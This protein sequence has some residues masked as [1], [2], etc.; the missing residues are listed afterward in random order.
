MRPES[1]SGQLA[2]PD[3]VVELRAVI[4][5]NLNKFVD[6]AGVSQSELARAVGVTP[7]SVSKWLTGESGID[8][9]HIKPV[10]DFLGIPMHA[11]LGEESSYTEISKDGRRAIELLDRL[12]ATGRAKALSYMEDLVATGKYS[13]EG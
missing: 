2:S 8:P 7:R 1:K 4:R 13:P 11:L 6:E 10:C 3:A 5:E 9:D 12:D